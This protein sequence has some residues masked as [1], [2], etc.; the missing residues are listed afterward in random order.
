[1]DRASQWKHLNRWLMCRWT[2]GCCV[3]LRAYVADPDERWARNDAAKPRV[4]S[5]VTAVKVVYHAALCQSI[6]LININYVNYID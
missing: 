6:R 4:F 2:A 1:M 3:E 5:P